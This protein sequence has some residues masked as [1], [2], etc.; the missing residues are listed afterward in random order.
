ML[1]EH[2]IKRFWSKADIRGEDECWNWKSFLD[3]KGYG[4]CLKFGEQR[5]I[6]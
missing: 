2:Y 6:G 5:A 1:L 4:R 3:E